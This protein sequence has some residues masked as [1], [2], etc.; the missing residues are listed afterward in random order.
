VYPYNLLQNPFPGNPTPTLNVAKILGGKRHQNALNS[1]KNCVN[2]L[3]LKL[4]DNKNSENDLFKIVTVI[5]DVGSGK[6]HLSLHMKTIPD[7]V[8][9]AI[10]CYV[11]LAQVHPREIDTIFSSIIKG[12][13]DDY[14]NDMMKKFIEY[15]KHKYSEYPKLVKKTIKYGFFDTL[16]GNSIDEKLN[17][18]LNRKIQPS[19]NHLVELMS[20][21]FSKVEILIIFEIIKK[22]TLNYSDLKTF[23][24]LMLVLT[25]VSSINYKFFNKVTLFQIDE[26]DANNQSLDYMKGLINFHIP[27]SILMLITTPSC[28]SDISSVSPSLFDRLEKANYKIDL[29]GSNTFEEIDDIALEYIRQNTDEL[30]DINKSDLS[31]KI[32]IIYDEFPD[33]RNIRSVLNILYHSIEISSKKN[34]PNID[35]QSIEEAIKNVYPGL[36]L[37]GSIM[38]IPIS[39]FIKMRKMSI[40]KN[41]LEVGIRDAVKNLIDYVEEFGTVKKYN[42]NIP[43]DYLDAVYNDQL[44]KKIGIAIAIDSDTSKNFDK[45]VKSTKRISFVDKLI[46]LTTNITNIKNNATIFVTVDRWK[47]ADLLYFSNKYANKEIKLEDP[48]KAILLAKSI[49]L[50]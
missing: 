17:H 27:Y 50:F 31:S 36:R 12:F 44:G 10:I 23:D 28:Y 18:V 49:Q 24:N 32:K 14:F 46:I 39:D 25:N 22:G 45:I 42:D 41:I 21:D 33:F 8:N 13:G 20:N 29:A 1:I 2:D 47:L 34:S 37:R 15:L 3:I 35:E 7:I 16:N 30:S 38:S 40:D 5:Q 6:T 48:Q 9:K 26:F 4:N 19:F 11:D 43:E